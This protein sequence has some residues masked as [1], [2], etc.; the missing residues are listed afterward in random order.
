MA[1]RRRIFEPEHEMFRDTVRKFLAAEVQPHAERW[2]Q[3]GIVD[4]EAWLKAGEAGL[5]MLWADEKYGGAGIDDLRYDQVLLEEWMSRGEGGFY[6]PLHNRLVGPYLDKLCTDEQKDRFLPGCVRGETILA[7]AM[8]EPAAGSDL[9]GMRTRA[10]DKGD[11]WLLNGSKTYIS[12]GILADL[13]VVAA[14]TSPDDPRAIGLFLVERGMSGFERGR[15]LKKIGMPA[16]DTAELFFNDVEVPKRN[17]LGDPKRGFQSLM[18][19][20]AE[21]RL[22]GAIRFLAH[23]QHAFAITLD[24]VQQRRMFGRTLGDFQN[25]RFQ[26]ASMRT[27]LDMA[28]AFVDHC[29]LEALDGKLTAEIAAEAKLATSEI[30]GRV[31]DQCVQLHGGAGYMEE[32]EIARMYTDARVSRIFAGSS[33]IMRE[34]IGRSL[35][36]DGRRKN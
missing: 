10:E 26:M 18:R 24:F 11:H 20:L 30:Q 1:L 3:Q 16:Q 8:S 32:Y 15:K 31:V 21:E 17:E 33:E 34:I 5:L 22:L 12:N 36:L 35:G 7:I 2:R 13:V 29:V 27:E 9:S 25:T 14:K 6:V 23:A 4:R 28:Q 19:F